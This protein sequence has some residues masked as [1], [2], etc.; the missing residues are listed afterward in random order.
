[1][2]PAD[3]IELAEAGLVGAVSVA[4]GASSHAAIVARGLGVPMI[5]G[6]S[7]EVLTLSPGLAAVLDADYGELVVG[8]GAGR[9][10]GVA[11][12]RSAGVRRRR[13][14]R[15]SPTMHAPQSHR[16]RRTGTRSSC[17]AT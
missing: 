17:C 15:R 12:Q 4:G 1:M 16:R 10:E 13:S 6:A 2:S 14:P 5:A 7:P 11:A 9:G 3:L 8:G